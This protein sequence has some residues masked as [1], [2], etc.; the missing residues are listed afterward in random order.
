MAK[1]E[2]KAVQAEGDVAA[3]IDRGA[4]IDA[5]IKNLGFEDKGIKTQITNKAMDQLDEGELSVRLLGKTS[6]AVVSGVEK[7]ELN[8]ASEQYPQVLAAVR[9]GLLNGIVSRTLGITIAAEDVERAAAE[10]AKVGIAATVTETIKLVGNPD[11]SMVGS[12]Q[13]GEAVVALSKCVKN[14]LSFRV[15]YER[16]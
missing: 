1:R 14:D 10:L 8:P 5:Q 2:I 3:I 11:F 9:A 4:D 6:A 13:A 12:V 16:V 7:I 15:K